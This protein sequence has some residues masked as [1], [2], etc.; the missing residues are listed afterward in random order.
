MKVYSDTGEG[1][2]YTK[3]PG[4][5]VNFVVAPAGAEY[6]SISDALIAAG[7]VATTNNRV[8]VTV[9]PGTY[10]EIPLIV[11]DYVA[12]FA[13][14]RHEVTRIVPSDPTSHAITIGTDCELIGLRVKWAAKSDAGT[15]SFYIP[16]GASDIELHDCFSTNGDIGFLCESNAGSVIGRQINIIGGVGTCG[17]KIDNGGIMEVSDFMFTGGPNLTNLVHVVDGDLNITN[18]HTNNSTEFVKGL[19]VESAGT[20]HIFSGIFRSQGAG[21]GILCDGGV[22]HGAA[23]AAGSVATGLETMNGAE[24]ALTA[25]R[26]D[27]SVTTH[28]TANSATD[29]VSISG[30]SMERSKLVLHPS[31]LVHLS[32][33][34]TGIAGDESV[35]VIG[36]SATGLPGRGY[37]TIMGEGD[38]YAWDMEVHMYNVGAASGTR[39]TSVTAEARSQTGSIFGFSAGAAVGDCLYVANPIPFPGLKMS[40]VTAMVPAAAT[41]LVCEIWDGAAWDTVTTM[42]RQSSY[43]FATRRKLMFSDTGAAQVRFNPLALSTW[44]ADEDILDTL[45]VYGQDMYIFRVRVVGQAPTVVPAIEYFEVHTNRFEVNS[46]GATEYFGRSRKWISSPPINPENLPRGASFPANEDITISANITLQR[47]RNEFGAVGLGQLQGCYNVPD[48]MDTSAPLRM[49]IAWYPLTAAAGNVKWQLDVAQV[50]INSILNGTLPEQYYTKTII[51]S[52]VA[53]MLVTTTFDI[54]VEDA[55]DYLLAFRLYRNGGVG[56]DT[57]GSSAVLDSIT[58][59]SLRWQ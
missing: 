19:W 35:C 56:G 9:Y 32:F 18:V 15:A 40:V 20:C 36:E 38:S 52:G 23:V 30:G 6:S 57:Y 42:D 24:V 54:N 37:E 53:K 46:G 31:S 1:L 50:S 33:L 4:G 28:L 25:F 10:T 43:P 41:D 22:I 11:P 51:A 26:I 12:V 34:D 59:T 55:G 58:F 7:L 48:A 2:H 27:G 44:T 47:E 21:T 13:P 49:T 39:F 5:D 45:P 8:M 14:G 16:A 17:I 29:T 3:L